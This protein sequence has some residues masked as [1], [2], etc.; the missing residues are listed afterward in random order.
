MLLSTKRFPIKTI[1][2]LIL[3]LSLSS[4]FSG[5][6]LLQMAE[7]SK[8][9]YRTSTSHGYQ[10]GVKPDTIRNVKDFIADE[11]KFVIL[12]ETPHKTLYALQN[13]STS[14]KKAMISDLADYCEDI[15]GEV[16]FGTQVG[17]AISREFSSVELELS[18]I[19]SDYKE[20]RVRSYSWWM[21]C[22]NSKDDFEIKRK[23]GTYRFVIN[24]KKAQELGYQLRWFMDYYNVSALELKTIGQGKWS[25]ASFLQF[26]SL[27]EYHG[28]KSL[29]SN[30]YTD[31]IPTHIN[32]YL[33]KQ[34]DPES[35]EK[36]YLLGQGEFVC[37]DTKEGKFDFSF[38]I[39]YI[40]K[41]RSL[42]YTKK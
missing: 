18:S 23:R 42:I 5:C 27:C 34:I 35:T 17:P 22:V 26:A 21:K 25:Y 37:K 3:T 16:I 13:R 39:K 31:N 19:K 38:D 24:H 10:N 9:L 41:Y 12:A 15:K 1:I 28:G 30:Q 6:V 40:S 32:T 2:R 4:I 11:N 36:K 7:E 29:I 20:K 14:G 33:L 8:E